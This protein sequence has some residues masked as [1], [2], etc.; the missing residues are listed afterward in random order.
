[1]KNLS[2]HSRAQLVVLVLCS[3]L[4]LQAVWGMINHGFDVGCLLLLLVGIATGHLYMLRIK[5]DITLMARLGDV[6]SQVAAGRLRERITHIN[7]GDE[8]GK[9]CWNFNDMLD[10]LETCFREQRTA[11]AY[12]AERKYFRRVLPAG[13]HGEF[14][15][16][17]DRTNASMKKMAENACL[18]QRNE[19]LSELG[20]LNTRNLLKNLRMNQKDMGGVARATDELE[21][22][23]RE[24]ASNSEAS[25]DQV[26]HV[27]QALSSITERVN[28]TSAAIADLNHLAENV[29]SSV[30]VIS[31]IA[32]QTNLLALNAAIEAARAGEQ[33]R[34]FAVVADEVR[35][36]AEKSKL[37]STEISSVMN[38]LRQHASTMLSDSEAMREM[39]AGSSQQAAGAEQRFEAMAHSASR[40]LEQISYVHDVS[41]SS[42]AKID[43][44]FYK[45][46]GYIGVIAGAEAPDARK[47][48]DVGVH[49][50]RFGRW[51]DNKAKELGFDSLPAYR[52]IGGPHGVVHD[53]IRQ[54][55]D[56]ALGDWEKD[57]TLRRQIAQQFRDAEAASDKVFNLLDAM[58]KQRHEQL[59][60]T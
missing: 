5:C 22:L 42:L 56:L 35:K 24:N 21:D 26:M 52:D 16:A 37:A 9:L 3:L 2:F 54:A 31:D 15:D 19:L 25:R 41:F 43:M 30:M 7:C 55:A 34:G 6:A 36:L 1:M 38:T 50:C 59:A 23:S 27:V 32:D 29:S 11:L 49:D 20:Q 47:V 40:A 4:A 53:S 51:Y 10:Q 8:L 18:E 45:Q 58:I 44:L 57:V 13:L 46:N 39:A 28:Q 12:A 17:L 14:S 33:G 60:V 48:I